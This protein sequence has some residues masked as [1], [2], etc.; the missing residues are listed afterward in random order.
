MWRNIY[1]ERFRGQIWF[2]K[3]EEA[4]WRD[5][6][7]DGGKQGYVGGLPISMWHEHYSLHN[8][9]RDTFYQWPGRHFIW[10]IPLNL[11]AT[12]FKSLLSCGPKPSV[13]RSRTEVRLRRQLDLRLMLRLWKNYASPLKCSALAMPQRCVIK[14][15]AYSKLENFWKRR[16]YLLS[17]S[18]NLYFVFTTA[19]SASFLTENFVNTIFPFALA[20]SFEEHKSK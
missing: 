16:A 11:M 7:C 20:V 10:N 13:I 14:S 1:W 6:A 9:M 2:S 17:R 4:V 8:Y 5:E 19:K 18:I 15:A 12:E 3:K